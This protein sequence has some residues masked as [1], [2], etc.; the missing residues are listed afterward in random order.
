[1]AGV[2]RRK[3]A[4]AVAILMMVSFGAAGPTSARTPSLHGSASG[5]GHSLQPSFNA[6]IDQTNLTFRAFRSFGLPLVP[7]E[8]FYLELARTNP[9][10]PTHF[11]ELVGDTAVD[12]GPASWRLSGSVNGVQGYLADFLVDGGT[13]AGSHTYQA[14]FDATDTLDALTISLIVDVEPVAMTVTISTP[15]NPAQAHHP[16]TLYPELA[17]DGTGTGITGTIEWR[18]ADTDTVL[19]TR[20]VDDPALAFAS[21]PVGVRH[22]VASYSGDAEHA[23]ATSAVF[24]LTVAADIVEATGVGL[25]Y[26]TF[27]PVIDSYRDS[28]AIKGIRAEP[29]SVGVRVYNSSGLR[30][31]SASLAQAVGAYS[32]KWNGR[33]STGAVLSAGK[34][35]VVQTL[36][37]GFGTKRS[38]TAYVTLSHKRLVTHT[39]YVTK[40]GASMS[41]KGSGSG[42]AVTVSTSAGYA[43]LK[44]GGGWA[45]AG[46]ELYLP[47]AIV[48]KSVSFQV[49]AKTVLSAPP[50]YIA[51]Q[52]FGWCAR[53]S[54]TW[55]DSCFDHWKGIG[56]STGSLAWFSTSSTAA[57]N[58]SGRYV[59][60]LIEV[61]Y[62]T[63]YVY[64][65]RA[66]VVYAILE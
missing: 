57:V 62:G 64:K 66:K 32:Y 61:S 53:A 55:Y 43:K 9:V 13:T 19:D 16:I 65:A 48:Y 18:D 50:T 37:D 34:Y 14:I 54:T 33:T 23:P 60:G 38:Y 63:T 46:W 4:L 52:N 59:R 36:T 49:Y 27:Y 20:S 30:V 22:F 42:G 3:V 39:T 47:S 41:A 1:M 17:G 21:L 31:R 45:L 8:S 25:Q 29:L 10:G 11:A 24:M 56:N 35:K 15:T 44:A 2:V 5:A 51:M 28:V 7:G 26:T 58:R 6:P 40:L 12:L